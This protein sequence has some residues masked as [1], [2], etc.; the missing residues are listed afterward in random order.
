LSRAT[1][2]EIG[3]KTGRG[4]DLGGANLNQLKRIGI[5]EKAGGSGDIF[6]R[7]EEASNPAVRGMLPQLRSEE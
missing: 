7:I 1:A 2:N 6:F 5:T 4:R 3:E